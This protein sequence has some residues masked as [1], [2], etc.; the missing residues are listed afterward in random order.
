MTGI[1]VLNQDRPDIALETGFCMVDYTVAIV[2]VA[3]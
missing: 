1:L 2:L 3:F